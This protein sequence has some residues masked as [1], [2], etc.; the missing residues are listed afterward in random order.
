MSPRILIVDDDPNQLRLL[1]RVVSMRRN[2][3][4]V[5]TAADGRDAIEVLQAGAIDYVLTDLQTPEMDGLE[6]VAWLI[7]HQPDVAVCAMTAFP[8]ASAVGR[9]RGVDCLTKPLDVALLLERIDTVLQDRAHGHV[10]NIS[11]PSFLQLLEMER[12]TCTLVVELDGRAGEL[13]LVNGE[14]HAARLG[15]TSGEKAALHICA[16]DNP[17]ITIEP[18]RSKPER[19]IDTPMGF[20]IM[21]SIR[22]KDETGEYPQLDLPES[23]APPPLSEP[24]IKKPPPPP[25]P[26]AKPAAAKPP[27]PPPKAAPPPPKAAEAPKAATAPKPAEAP[28]PAAEADAPGPIVLKTRGGTSFPEDPSGNP[29]GVVDVRERELGSP[30]GPWSEET[31]KMA[32]AA[33]VLVEAGVLEVMLA[34]ADHWLV[35]RTLGDGA[36]FAVVV[37]PPG[38]Q[39]LIRAR[40]VLDR[41][42]AE[43]G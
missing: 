13:Y 21:E 14:L 35:S 16:W 8:D 24:P 26:L 37:V 2:D 39:H 25:P 1:A 4:T 43:H 9:L 29:T 18:L 22:V 40:S 27:P 42:V 7:S 11:L 6:L 31:E 10:S 33:S 34:G 41:L 5:L 36:R 23:D 32:L 12:K 28:N 30:L 17:A 20:L 15:T 3:L 19:T 38:N